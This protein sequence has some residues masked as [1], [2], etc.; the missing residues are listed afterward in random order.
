MQ[1]SAGTILCCLATAS[2]K[3]ITILTK[4]DK[5]LYFMCIFDSDKDVNI[6]IYAHSLSQQGIIIQN[7]NIVWNLTF[8]VYKMGR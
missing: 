2:D 7:I 8:L 6:D 5:Y 1:K 3:N 4:Y